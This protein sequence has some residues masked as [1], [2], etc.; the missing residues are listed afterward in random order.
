MR[1]ATASSAADVGSGMF[2]SDRS[3]PYCQLTPLI[4][5]EGSKPTGNPD[6]VNTAVF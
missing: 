6:N 5:A 2:G 4:I 1:P 3:V